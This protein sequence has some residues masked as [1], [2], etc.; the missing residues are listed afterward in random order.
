[1]NRALFKEKESNNN[2]ED[3]W[4]RLKKCINKLED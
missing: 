3:G 4:K 1:M 2:V